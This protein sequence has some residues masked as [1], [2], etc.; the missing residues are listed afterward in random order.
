MARRPFVLLLVPGLVAATLGVAGTASPAAAEPATVTV[1]GSFQQELG[2]PDDWQPECA[3]THLA[4]DADDGVWQ[5]SFPLPA[6]SWEYKAALDGTWAENY[7]AG[8]VRD[9]PNIGLSLAAAGQV[10]F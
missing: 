9:G 5:A 6:G 7:G 2:C 1:A 4:F 10:K 8:A 3:T